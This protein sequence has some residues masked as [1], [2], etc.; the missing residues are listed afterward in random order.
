MENSKKNQKRIFVSLLAVAL[1]LTLVL[2][3]I[4]NRNSLGYKNITKAIQETFGHDMVLG[5]HDLGDGYVAAVVYIHGDTRNE[6]TYLDS[7]LKIREFANR[8]SEYR[9]G[10]IKEISITVGLK[11]NT[12]EKNIIA[13]STIETKIL[14]KIEWMKIKNYEELKKHISISLM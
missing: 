12:T 3:Q 9:V 1:I 7:V 5:V 4:T 10:K 11:E 14:K 13:V 8:A 6:E 2:I